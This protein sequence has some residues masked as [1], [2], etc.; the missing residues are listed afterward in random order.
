[1]KAEDFPLSHRRQDHLSNT[2]RLTTQSV[3]LSTPICLHRSPSHSCERYPMS[4]NEESNLGDSYETRSIAFSSDS[5]RSWI[6]NLPPFKPVADKKRKRAVEQSSVLSRRQPQ[7][8]S[9]MDLPE[10]APSLNAVPALT[11]R[12]MTR[13]Q[14]SPR[15]KAVSSQPPRFMEIFDENA[16]DST[17]LEDTPRPLSKRKRTGIESDAPSLPPSSSKASTASERSRSPTKLV[18][19]LNL[20]DPLH[21]KALGSFQVINDS[22]PLFRI[23]SLVAKLYKSANGLGILDQKTEVWLLAHAMRSLC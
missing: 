21:S 11:A 16:E 14:S 15:K 8:S 3:D 9:L 23:K 22:H 19:L 2:E 17:D 12:K 5:I 10:N 13:R 7:R 6:E 4:H 1:M 20:Q 18:E